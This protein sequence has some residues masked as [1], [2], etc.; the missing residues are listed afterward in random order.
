[1]AGNKNSGRRTMT[2]ELK[3]WKEGLKRA[4][5]EELAESKVYNH[6]KEKVDVETGQGVKEIALPVYLKSKAD[7]K[8]V[9]VDIKN[10]T[11]M[12]IKKDED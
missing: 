2:E 11:G 5:I 3:K 8:D 6:L 7:K 9:T 12:T 1:M 10:I 4:T